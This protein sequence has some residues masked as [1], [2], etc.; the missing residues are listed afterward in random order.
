MDNVEAY[1]LSLDPLYLQALS[2]SSAL[3]SF[4]QR[5]AATMQLIVAQHVFCRYIL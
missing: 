4:C 1:K 2:E 5:L 3:G